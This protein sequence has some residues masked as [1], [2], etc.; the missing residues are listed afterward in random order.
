MKKIIDIFWL[1]LSYS[2]V[3]ALFYFLYFIAIHEEPKQ[4]GPA[5]SWDQLCYIRGGTWFSKEGKCVDIKE[6][7]LW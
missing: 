3:A 6:I 4:Y 1:I 7:K 2:I 5:I